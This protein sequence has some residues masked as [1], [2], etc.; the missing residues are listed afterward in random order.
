MNLVPYLLEL[1]GHTDDSGTGKPPTR[2]GRGDPSHSVRQDSCPTHSVAL[3]EEVAGHG[4]DEQPIL[5][6]S[7]DGSPHEALDEPGSSGHLIKGRRAAID[8][9]DDILEIRAREGDN[10]WLSCGATSNNGFNDFFGRC[11]IKRLMVL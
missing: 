1:G 8:H 10:E 3:V 5:Q 6:Q 2:S 4:L 11:H 7:G 9:D